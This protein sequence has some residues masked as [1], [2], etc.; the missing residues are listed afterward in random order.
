MPDP[1]ARRSLQRMRTPATT[2]TETTTEEA[3]AVQPPD[4]E[5]INQR[6]VAWKAG[7][8]GAV[9]VIVKVLAARL[10]VLVAVSGGIGLT[11]VALEQPDPYRLGALAIYALA[12]VCPTIYLASR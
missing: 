5:L 6:Q 9:N 12:V 10:V 8:L 1:P 2:S 3:G 4:P 11:W 7:V